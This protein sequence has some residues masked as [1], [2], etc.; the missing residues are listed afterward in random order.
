MTRYA[1]AVLAALLAVSTWGAT[2]AVD[3]TFDAVEWF[4]LLGAVATAAGTYLVPNTVEHPELHA[5]ESVVD[6]PGDH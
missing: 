4:G 6:I 5:D 3:G 2:A 1:K